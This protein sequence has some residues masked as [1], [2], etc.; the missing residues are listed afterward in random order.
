VDRKSSNLPV[1]SLALSIVTW[2]FAILAEFLP[3]ATGTIVVYLTYLSCF[4]SIILAVIAIRRKNE[5]DIR[6]AQI[7]LVLDVLFVLAMIYLF[8]R[9][10]CSPKIIPP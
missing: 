1:Y 7:A 10:A 9:L 4:A 5:R 2:I 8:I 6:L 3:Q